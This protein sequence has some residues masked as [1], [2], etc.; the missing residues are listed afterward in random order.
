MGIR[1][2]YFQINDVSSLDFGIVISEGRTFGSP[3]RVYEEVSVPG[4]NGTVLFDEGYYENVTV[5]YTC[6]LIN[7]EAEIDKFRA[8]LAHHVGYVKLEDTYHPTEYR[9]A[10]VENGLDPTMSGWMLSRG[11]FQVTFSCKPQR[12]LK[13]GDYGTEYVSNL[14]LYNPT[15]YEAEPIIRIFGSGTLTV[16]DIQV[17]IA[18]NP[19][20]YIDLDSQ[21]QDAYCGTDNANQYVTLTNQKYPTL[22]VPSTN[23]TLGTG[24]EKIILYPKWWTL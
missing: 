17:N 3:K 15:W 6:S 14:T 24:I 20:N 4:R 8:W 16:G 22:L 2:N 13:I 11:D 10:K 21:T 7:K 1:N 23:I 19:L 12:Y 5:S 9:M 18:T